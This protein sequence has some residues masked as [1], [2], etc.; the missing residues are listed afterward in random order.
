LA[1]GLLSLRFAPKF[2]AEQC[3][4]FCNALQLFKLGY[5]WGGP[6]SLIVPYQLSSLRRMAPTE[7]LQGGFVRLSVGLENADDLINDIA[8]A[9]RQAGM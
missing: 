1:A 9:L 2:T 4:T 5:S 3:E 6:M 8:Q 7:L